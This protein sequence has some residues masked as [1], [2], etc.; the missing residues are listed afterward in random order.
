MAL[1]TVRDST[2]CR[3]LQWANFSASKAKR[4]VK[5]IIFCQVCIKNMATTCV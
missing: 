3:S 2:L 4:L 5:A 1:F